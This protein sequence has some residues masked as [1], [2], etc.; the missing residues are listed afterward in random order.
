MVNVMLAV[1]VLIRP[2]GAG[3]STRQVAKRGWLA[4]DGGV[5]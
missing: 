2:I 5:G 3:S 4:L 1:P